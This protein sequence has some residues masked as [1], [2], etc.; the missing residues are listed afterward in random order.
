[1]NFNSY[2]INVYNNNHFEFLK[3]VYFKHNAKLDSE[4]GNNTF[5]N[6]ISV[7]NSNERIEE[8]S[9]FYEILSEENE[10][11]GIFEVDENHITI[12]YIDSIN[13]KKSIGSFCINEIKQLLQNNYEKATVF[14]SIYSTGFYL[15]NNFIKKHDEIRDIQG[16]KY[17]LMELHL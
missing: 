1:M 13:H 6:F 12:L 16:M 11:L 15:K 14:A 8:N 7:E 3:N 4:Q 9:S 10:M 2:K 5:V 17:H